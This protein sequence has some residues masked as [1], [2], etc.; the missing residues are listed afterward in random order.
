MLYFNDMQHVYCTIIHID[1]LR[2]I[3]SSSYIRT[4][5]YMFI[6]VLGVWRKDTILLRA[7]KK[8]IVGYG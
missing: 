8:V 2:Y 4:M 3:F 7:L 6:T 5:L 1:K